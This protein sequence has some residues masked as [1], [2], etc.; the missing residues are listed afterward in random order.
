MTPL[1]P[2]RGLLIPRL[3]AADEEI[4]IIAPYHAQCLK[5]R[6][7]LSSVAAGI[8]VGSTEEFQGQV[9]YL[10]PHAVLVFKD[11]KNIYNICNHRSAAS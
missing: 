2:T 9:R 3:L 7:G 11:A 10:M 8:K 1:L 5:I 6:K 4:G